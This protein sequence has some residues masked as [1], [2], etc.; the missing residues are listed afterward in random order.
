[1]TKQRVI[2]IDGAIAKIPLDKGG[3]VAIIDTAMVRF[4]DDHLWHLGFDGYPR[5]L[6]DGTNMYLHRVLFGRTD[7]GIVIDHINHNKLDN[8]LSNLRAV[9]HKQNMR[10]ISMSRKNTSGHLGVHWDSRRQKWVAQ[11]SNGENHQRKTLWLG[12]FKDI[13]EA[14]N[15]RKLAEKEYGI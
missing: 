1:M 15:A 8:R 6:V 14:I 5:A 9:T 13:K 7:R 2:S 3:K 10:N 12:A 11:I 4:V